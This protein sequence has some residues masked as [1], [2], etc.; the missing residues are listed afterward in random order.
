MYSAGGAYN[1]ES[2]A[3]LYAIWDVIKSVVT[4]DAAGGTEASPITVTYGQTYGA[5]PTPVKQFFSF[6]GWF[7]SGGT[8]IRSSDTV[9]ITSTITLYAHW[10]AVETPWE[11]SA[12]YA[13]IKK[14]DGS[15]KRCLIGRVQNDMSVKYGPIYAAKELLYELLD[16]VYFDGTDMLMLPIVMEGSDTLRIGFTVWGTQGNLCGWYNS[17]VTTNYSVYTSAT[18]SYVRYN[19]QLKRGWAVTSKT[20]DYDLVITP[21]GY[22]DGQGYT[23]TITPATFTGGNP[24]IGG[25][26]N[27]SSSKAKFKCRYFT[28]DGKIDLKP[29]KRLSDGAVGMLDVLT[30]TF[31]TGGF[32]H[33]TVP[34]TLNMGTP[35]GGE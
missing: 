14:E 21:N 29:A 16:Y 11:I 18:S 8:Q 35:N 5:L 20:N 12:G 25:L 10:T 19:G 2:N 7:T 23:D 28:V 24:A 31:Y 27:S 17:D 32:I 33:E 1:V 22:S 9:T 4:F 3:T 13:Y 6:D 34:N 15:F 26:P 30:K